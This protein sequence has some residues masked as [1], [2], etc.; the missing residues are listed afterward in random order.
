MITVTIED[1]VHHFKR[2][3]KD[4]KY[5]SSKIRDVNLKLEECA[6]RLLGVKSVRCKDVV[7]ENSGN[8]YSMQDKLEQMEIESRLIKERQIYIDRILECQ[9]IETIEDK[10]IIEMIIEIY[11]FG[12][13]FED[14]AKKH[15]ISKSSMQDKINGAITEILK[16]RYHTEKKR[17][18]MIS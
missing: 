16:V 6:V 4:V 8:P 7:F 11:V 18:I 2:S 9:I 15:H 3:L 12:K 10:E 13:R 17:V 5:Y 14:V 1:E